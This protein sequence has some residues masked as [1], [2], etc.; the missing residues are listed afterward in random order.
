MSPIPCWR[1][2]MRYYQDPTNLTFREALALRGVD[3]IKP[4]L[5]LVCGKV[6]ARKEEMVDMVGT[7][8]QGPAALRA[9]Y[10]SLD[11]LGQRAVQE[12]THDDEGAF[13]RE[14]FQVRSGRLPRFGRD[15]R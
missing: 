7:A 10:E 14:R 5:A 2:P 13:R 6:K 9:L 11:D 1:G 12:A 8:L 4:L 15:R 3:E